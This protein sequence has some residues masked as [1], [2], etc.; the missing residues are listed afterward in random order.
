MK[1]IE[2]EWKIPLYK[3]YSDDDDINSITKI[4]KR[5]NRWAIGPEI[6][7]LE[8]K[9]SEYV[10]CDYC[11][12]FNSGT[13]ALHASLLSYNITNTDEVIVP[14]F[15]FISTV[16]SVLFVN[17]TPVFS[18]IEDETYGLDPDLL[19]N[20]ISKKTKIILPMDYGGLPCKIN[21]IQK[22]T[23]EHNLILLEDAAEALG[24]KIN[25]KNIGSIS[26]LSIFSFCG[27]KVLTTGEGGAAVTNSKEIYEKLK[28]IRSHGRV[29]KINYF[30]NPDNANYVGIGYNWRMSS[31]TAALGIS[32]LQKLDKLI[33]LRQ[34]NAEYLLS[35]LSK[36]SQIILP[37]S[38]KGYDHIY[39]MFTVRLRDKEIRNKLQN[40][41]LKKKIFCKVYFNPIHLT[42]LY[43]KKFPNYVEKL[44]VTEKISNQVLT[45]PIYP[46]M[47]NEEMNY[48][49]DSIDEFFE[50]N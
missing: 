43:K 37:K 10:G 39:Q 50:N 42:D 17:A 14:S 35:K 3:I 28:I 7:E 45:L 2:S 4:I 27:N 32:Q 31:M 44:N 40:H 33:R 16:N 46:N 11:V 34:K 6:E 38:P 25:G 13:S 47:T 20:K 1:N 24:A 26:D 41:L 5:G 22:I 49:T 9:I 15:S 8:E 30:E 23:N 12:T 19:E 21:E 48:L 18:D 29:D 36:H